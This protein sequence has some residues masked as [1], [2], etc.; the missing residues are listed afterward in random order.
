MALP[1]IPLGV[2]GHSVLVCEQTVHWHVWFCGATR[3][4]DFQMRGKSIIE[5]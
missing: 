5:I 3:P 4:V 1:V 2:L